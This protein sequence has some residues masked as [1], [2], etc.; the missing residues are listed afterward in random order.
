MELVRG[1]VVVITRVPG[2][3]DAVPLQLAR[4]QRDGARLRNRDGDRLGGR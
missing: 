1:E 2:H 3:Q 4:T